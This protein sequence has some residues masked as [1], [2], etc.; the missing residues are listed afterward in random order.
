MHTNTG[1]TKQKHWA[2]R[3]QKSDRFEA[4]KAQ[5]QKNDRFAEQLNTNDG[6]RK[7]EEAGR[8]DAGERGHNDGAT[9]RVRR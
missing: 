9:Q 6:S 8:E 1:Q 5:V 2:I 4:S 3:K 7:K